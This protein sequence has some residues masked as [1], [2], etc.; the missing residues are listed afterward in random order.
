MRLVGDDRQLA[1][2]GAGG[3]LRD[4]ERTHGAVTLAEVRRFSHADG[5]PNRAEAAASLALRRGDPTG[6]GYYLDHGRIHVGDDHRR[7]PTRRSPRG[8]PTVLQ[9]WTRC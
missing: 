7:P 4:I 5:S 6:L 3:L 9:G 8:R 2:V 1:A